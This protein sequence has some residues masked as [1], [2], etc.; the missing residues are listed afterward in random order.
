[1]LVYGDHPRE[2]DALAE[3]RALAI[4]RT[5][6]QALSPGLPRHSA[7]VSLLIRV[8]EWAQGTLDAESAQRGGDG[9]TPLARAC[10]AALLALGHAVATSWTQ[11]FRADLEPL[12][13]LLESL[14]ALAPREPVRCK[15]PEGYAFY[16]LYPEA[17]LEAARAVPSDGRPWR[18]IGIRGIGTGLAGMVAA[19]LGTEALCTVRPGGHPFERTLSLSPDLSARLVEEARAGW[20]FAVVDEGPG[21]SGSSF[22]AVADFLEAHGAA[23]ESVTFF[24]S[25][26]GDLGP[27]AKAAH[28]ERW[29]R[30][31]KRVV[32]F[33]SLLLRPSD[34]SHALTRW[35]EDLT[36]VAEGAPEDVAG[37]GWRR[38]FLSG[39]PESEWPAVHP[40]QERRKYLLRAGGR[41][42]LLKFVG[43]GAHGAR[44]YLQAR[45][46]AEA[47]FGVPVAGLRHGFLVQPWLEEARP[48]SVVPDAVDRWALVERVGAYLGFRSHHF[49]AV[50]D[51]CGASPRALWEMARYN[52]EQTLGR[53]VS[54]ALDAWEPRLDALASAVRRTV[55]DNRMHAWEWLVLPG[56]R[57]LKADGVDHARGHDLVGCQDLAWDLAGAAVE[58]ALDADALGALCTVVERHKGHLPS[59]EVLRFHRQAY[60][61]FQLGHHMLAAMSYDASAPDEA[62]RLRRAADRYAE[63]LRSELAAFSASHGGR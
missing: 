53:A 47:G 50:G 31:D 51:E 14:A 9:D 61:A 30:A 57:V 10:E 34:P 19:G 7:L 21:L 22:G 32:D 28:R 26:A 16:A 44:A 43:L 6:V 13:P 25:H 8:G 52:T 37:G 1:M 12:T 40:W 55:T 60:L 38:L 59:P 62:A 17:Y 33:E 36:G 63:L 29:A 4:V 39:A 35:V 48:L 54:S 18:V 2:V 3:A 15:V 42:W 56:G 24:P 49:G 46:L 58:L 23:P 45:A 27:Q 5:E 20:R 11:G 41:S